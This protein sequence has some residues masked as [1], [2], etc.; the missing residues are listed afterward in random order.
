MQAAWFDPS[1]LLR[2]GALHLAKPINWV[3]GRGLF[4][5][6]PVLI[7][8]DVVRLDGRAPDLPGVSQGTNGLASGNTTEEAQF[9]GVCELIERDAT[10]LWSLLPPAQQRRRAALPLANG[11]VDDLAQRI[12]AAGLQLALFDLTS[13][14]AVPTILA[15]VRLEFVLALFR[16]CIGHRHA[17]GPGA[18]CAGYYWKRRRA[19]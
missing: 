16:D 1:R 13:D 9:H 15:L 8:R 19:G 18:C 3:A 17:S 10:T 14:I 4:S 2:F 12:R 6:R 7:P 5:G 11:F